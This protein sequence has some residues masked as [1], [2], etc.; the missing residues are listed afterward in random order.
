LISVFTSLQPAMELQQFFR[1][2]GEGTGEA[3]AERVNQ[4]ADIVFPQ[5]PEDSQDDISGSTLSI[6]TRRQCVSP[7]L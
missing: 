2:C 4:M 7:F 1:E 6:P 5:S 3:I